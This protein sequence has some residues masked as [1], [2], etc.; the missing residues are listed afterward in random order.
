VSLLWQR[1]KYGLFPARHRG[2]VIPTGP[3]FVT[4]ADAGRVIELSKR[5][6]R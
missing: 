3:H 4:A 1:A 6:Y 5:S 2:A